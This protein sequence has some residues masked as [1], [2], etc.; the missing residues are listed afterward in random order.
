[1]DVGVGGCGG[2]IICSWGNPRMELIL[3]RA[4]IVPNGGDIVSEYGMLCLVD[5]M[6]ARENKTLF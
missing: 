2:R 4:D 1:M 5:D 6:C 3:L